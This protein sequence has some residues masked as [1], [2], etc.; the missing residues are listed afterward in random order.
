MGWY[1]LFFFFKKKE[2]NQ[3][4]EESFLG[5]VNTSLPWNSRA[6]MVIG[7]AAFVGK[8]GVWLLV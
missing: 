5:P 8:N 7:V 2:E 1:L 3:V 4:S 6:W